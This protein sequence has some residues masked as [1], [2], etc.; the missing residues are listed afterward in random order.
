M[1]SGIGLQHLTN[2]DDADDTLLQS[3]IEFLEAAFDGP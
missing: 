2:P 1:F 3:A